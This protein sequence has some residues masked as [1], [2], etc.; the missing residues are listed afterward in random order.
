MAGQ[1]NRQRALVLGLRAGHMQP[2]AWFARAKLRGVPD[3]AALV[4]FCANLQPKPL[5]RAARAMATAA[6]PHHE[7]LTRA[8]FPADT[9]AQL[10]GV[11]SAASCDGQAGRGA[12]LR[13]TRDSD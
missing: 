9:V 12:R 6:D 13:R 5:V 10:R 1:I 8:G 4:N 2:I 7:V 11:A 3:F